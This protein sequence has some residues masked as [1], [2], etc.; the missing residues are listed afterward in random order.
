MTRTVLLLELIIALLM[1]Q[2]V[3]SSVD[4]FN[5]DSNEVCNITVKSLNI[6]QS[7]TLKLLKTNSNVTVGS[8]PDKE[9]KNTTFVNI[10]KDLLKIDEQSIQFYKLE[11]SFDFQQLQPSV[12][13]APDAVNESNPKELLAIEMNP[14]LNAIHLAYG[15]HLPL[16]ISPDVIWHLIVS[17]T[18]IH[19]NKYSEQLRTRFVDHEGKKKLVVRRDDFV[20]NSSAN[21]WHEMIDEFV[22]K[23]DNFTKLEATDLFVSNFSTTSDVSKTCS[24]IVIMDSFQKYFEYEFVTLCGIP[25]FRILGKKSDWQIIKAKANKLAQIIPEFGIWINSLNE[26]LQQF[27]DIYDDKIDSK[28]W[29]EIYKS[30]QS[31]LFLCLVIEFYFQSHNSIIYWSKLLISFFLK[32]AL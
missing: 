11:K 21:P 25:E 30:K 14:F 7:L 9:R 24:K 20:Y 23:I 18:S 12:T 4:F 10:M 31:V 28:F 22:V 5:T 2:L 3:C 13:A 26:I 1:S 15:Y 29:N 16:T 19:I 32:I 6:S 17:A 8:I 27:I